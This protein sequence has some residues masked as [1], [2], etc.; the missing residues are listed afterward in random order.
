M[1]AGPMDK[2][3]L[4][5]FCIYHA[6]VLCIVV[7][8]H[9][10]PRSARQFRQQ[11]DVLGS[12]SGQRVKDIVQKRLIYVVMFQLGAIRHRRV[13]RA[14]E[15]CFSDRTFARHE[16]AGIKTGR[17]IF[18]LHSGDVLRL[19]DVGEVRI[20]INQIKGGL[21]EGGK[22]FVQRHGHSD[23]GIQKNKFFIRAEEARP[24]A[25]HSGVTALTHNV[26]FEGV[27]ARSLCF[28]DEIKI[29]LRR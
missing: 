4:P 11:C 6:V 13:C 2:R 27:E 9:A 5:T 10:C 19:I 3:H 22:E 20:E 21:A 7:K 15:L 18:Q 29:E 14:P 24:L 23:V 12:A 28:G 17:M 25:E 8:P 1:A 26:R 16:R